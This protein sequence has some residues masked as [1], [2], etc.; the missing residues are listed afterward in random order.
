VLS[1]GGIVPLQ[2]ILSTLD[3]TGVEPFGNQLVLGLSLIPFVGIAFG[4]GTGQDSSW[5]GQFEGWL[6]G[7]F[8]QS[9]AN[10]I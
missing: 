4:Y 2:G 3:L 6:N 10:A 5:E 9:S 7:N 1:N 8:S